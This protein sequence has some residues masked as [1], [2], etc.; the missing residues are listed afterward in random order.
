M[1]I[2][3]I[4]VFT[5]PIINR[6]FSQETSNKF[7]YPC[8]TV[9]FSSNF[10][11]TKDIKYTR[12]GGWCE[13]F[14]KKQGLETE[15]CKKVPVMKNKTF[16]SEDYKKLTE[17]EKDYL[18]SFLNN[19]YMKTSGLVNDNY[20][21]ERDMQRFLKILIKLKKDL[22]KKYP[23]GWKF[24]A[25]GGSP[26]LF[27]KI[28]E[29]LGADTIIIPYSK[30]A[31]YYEGADD[32]DFDKY[33]NDIGFRKEDLNPKTTMIYAD[34]IDTG[35]TMNMFKNNILKTG[36][37]LPNDKYVNFSDLLNGIIDEDEIDVIDD[38]FL[39]RMQIASYSPCPSME[40]PELYKNASKLWQN[41]EWN[42]TTKLMNFAVLDCLDEWQKMDWIS[43]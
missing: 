14:Y 1:K 24:V 38:M 25:I 10:F 28:L 18:R 19:D 22:D 17:Q 31:H 30:I 36:R 5:R 20:T 4:S 8:D 12:H 3:P 6:N 7:S 32:I 2:N 13:F 43:F 27:A 16:T 9:S 34:Y 23:D 40:K 15:I 26:S 39:N 11:N 21:I 37:A 42:F 35:R 33:F 29:E 41:F